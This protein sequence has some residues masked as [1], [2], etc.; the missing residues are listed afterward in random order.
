[1]TGHLRSHGKTVGGNTRR[2]GE[3]F[4]ENTWTVPGEKLPEEF[5]GKNHRAEWGKRR[6][7][8]GFQEIVLGGAELLCG[9]TRKGHLTGRRG[10]PSL[11]DDP[12]EG[13][14]EGRGQGGRVSL[15]CSSSLGTQEKNS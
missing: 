5:G 11:L 3:S 12:E 13:G 4:I 6:C 15:A 1:M 10:R 2:D 9:R 7:C 14:D 8:S